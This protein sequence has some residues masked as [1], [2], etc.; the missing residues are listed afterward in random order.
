M[1]ELLETEPARRPSRSHRRRWLGGI[2][3]GVSLMALVLGGT[4]FA[5]TTDSPGELQQTFLEKLAGKLGITP[6]ELDAAMTAAGNETI[7]EALASGK[8][9][10]D[11]AAALRERV[12]AEGFSGFGRRGHMGHHP[13]FRH[14][15]LETIA[16]TLGITSDELRA[17]LESGSTLS[18]VITAHG[19]TVETVVDALVAET[20]TRLDEKVAA[21]EITQY[22][23]DTIMAELPAR[24]TEAIENGFP[25]PGFP[26]ADDESSPDAETSSL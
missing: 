1:P 21:G 4:A 12:E 5:A 18:E 17:E 3:I 8:I 13:W 22:Q 10:E 11:Q 2:G 26:G 23:A 16:T 14:M 20:Q 24:L 9:T 19:S 15:S 6:D 7:D 25:C